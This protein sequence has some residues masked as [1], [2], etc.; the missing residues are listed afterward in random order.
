MSDHT[1]VILAAGPLIVC[2]LALVL[3]ERSISTITGLMLAIWIY[4]GIVG[5]LA[6]LPALY[7]MLTMLLLISA[8]CLEMWD[9]RALAHARATGTQ[10]AARRH[11]RMLKHADEELLEDAIRLD[12]TARG[13]EADGLSQM[14]WDLVGARPRWQVAGV[15]PQNAARWLEA[16]RA[17]WQ[18]GDS[19]TDGPVTGGS[20]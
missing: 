2:A 16:S 17:G 19:R 3:G 13:G 10:P 11:Q 1:Q 9:Q 6:G 15:T 14:M 18:P 4:W 20:R 8:L 7:F 5:H 12:R